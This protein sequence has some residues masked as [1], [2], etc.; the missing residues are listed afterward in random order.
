MNFQRSCS[1]LVLPHYIT[2]KKSEEENY[3]PLSILSNLS[4]IH[5]KLMYNQL[6]D[7]FDTLF[8]QYQCGFREGFSAEHCLLAMIEKFEEAIDRENK[9]GALLTDLFKEFD[10]INH[11]RLIVKIYSYGVSSLSIKEIIILKPIQEND[12]YF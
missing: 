11:P 1:R 5:E 3:R 6:Y 4:K 8:F 9:F 7:Y 10:C 12:I 2:K